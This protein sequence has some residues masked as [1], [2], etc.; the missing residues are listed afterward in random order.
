M[1]NQAPALRPRNPVARRTV[2]VNF[3]V[4]VLESIDSRRGMENR[5]AYI[6][7]MIRQAWDRHESFRGP[8]QPGEDNHEFFGVAR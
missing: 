5:S 1:D 8:P 4:D 6:E 3:S 7:R 2:N